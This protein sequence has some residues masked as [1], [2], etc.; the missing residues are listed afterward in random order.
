[1]QNE[2]FVPWRA[3]WSAFAVFR[4][5]PAQ[6]NASGVTDR[7]L[8]SPDTEGIKSNISTSLCVFD[9]KSDF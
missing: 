9:V 7:F 2:Y 1:M 5:K 8:H 3:S 4:A 6:A